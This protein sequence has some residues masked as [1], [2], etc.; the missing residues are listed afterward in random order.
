MTLLCACQNSNE[1]SNYVNHTKFV[2]LPSDTLPAKPSSGVT[3]V[4]FSVGTRGCTTCSKGACQYLNI[5]YPAASNEDLFFQNS[6]WG[7]GGTRGGGH[8]PQLGERAHSYATETKSEYMYKV[9]K[10][11]IKIQINKS[12]LDAQRF[13]FAAN[14]HKLFN[15]SGF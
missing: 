3:S 13:S 12:H 11:I 10:K 4:K 6:K 9:D 1:P 8:R 14:S 2:N 15:I 7:V 5:L